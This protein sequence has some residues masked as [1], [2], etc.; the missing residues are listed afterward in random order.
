MPTDVEGQLA[1]VSDL[2]FDPIQIV[3]A[4]MWKCT[5]DS[6]TYTADL[7]IEAGNT[8]CARPAHL[9]HC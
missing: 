1:F 7:S 4:G 5:I 8:K 2:I 3:D 9:G 6:L